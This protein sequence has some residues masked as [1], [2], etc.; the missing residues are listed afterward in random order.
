MNKQPF[1]LELASDRVV[2]R[3]HDPALADLMFRS[4]DSER[5]RL[6]RFLL[7][8]DNTR[9][10]EDIHAYIR[11]TLEGREKGTVADYA[12]FDARTQTYMGNVGMH[13]IQWE[14]ACIE[15][16]YWILSAFEGKGFMSEAVRLLER[17]CFDMGFHRVEIRCNALNTRSAAVARRMGY[18]LEGTLRENS[19]EYGEYR[20]TLI[21]AKLADQGNRAVPRH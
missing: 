7:W 1:P 12:L 10:V 17:A 4:V 14:H 9:T 11:H 16:G 20:D 19:I 18:E 6:R 13:A 2:L 21:F 5:E 8:V 3:R 15:L